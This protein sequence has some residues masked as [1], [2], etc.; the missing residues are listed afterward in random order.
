MTIFV[1]PKLKNKKLNLL[2][3]LE[4]YVFEKLEIFKI[5]LVNNAYPIPYKDLR[6]KTKLS[7]ITDFLK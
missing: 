5:N 7:L 1:M 3:E 2:Q 6:N 4:E